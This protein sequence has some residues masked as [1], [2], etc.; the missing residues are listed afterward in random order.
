MKWTQNIRRIV[1]QRLLDEFGP[2]SEWHNRS[3]PTGNKQEYIA[4]LE[5]I[6]NGLASINDDSCTRGAVENQIMWGIQESQSV[7]L[8]TGAITN[9]VYNRAIALEVGLIES[10]DMPDYGLF[11]KK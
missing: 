4:F 1:Y 11:E 9:F 10:G 5:Q 3:N 2:C 7:C 6:A 8:N